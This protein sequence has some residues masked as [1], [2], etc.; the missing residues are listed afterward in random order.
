MP[1]VGVAVGLVWLA[2]TPAHVAGTYRFATRA[3]RA[4][5]I[6]G[7]PADF[8]S[9]LF[10]ITSCQVIRYRAEAF[11]A[12]VHCYDLLTST[13]L[14]EFR[15]EAGDAATIKRVLYAASFAA[16]EA[17]PG[18]QL[19]VQERPEPSKPTLVRT[20]PVWLGMVGGVLAAAVPPIPAP[21]L[22][23]RYRT[24]SP[25]ASPT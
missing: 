7:R 1:A 2:V 9:R 8:I 22:R 12:N 3:P 13:G 10:V 11:G 23:R 16:I 5:A 6:A 25:V 18:F 14:G 21:R 4:E 20:A 15:I 24:F 19:F 17:V